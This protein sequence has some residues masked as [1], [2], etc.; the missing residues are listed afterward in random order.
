MARVKRWPTKDDE[1]WGDYIA[2]VFLAAV[3]MLLISY[4]AG[5][6][7]CGMSVRDVA[8]TTANG[9]RATEVAAGDILRTECTDKYKAAAQLKTTAEIYARINALDPSCLPARKSYGALRSARLVLLAAIVA[10]QVTQNEAALEDALRR[11]ATAATSA[12]DTIR[13]L[14]EP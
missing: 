8:V 9:M 14:E 6:C 13:R 10:Y 3:V 1:F 4:A 2:N 11:A 7:G 12:S 5:L